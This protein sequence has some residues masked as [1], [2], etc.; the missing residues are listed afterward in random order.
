MQHGRLQENKALEY[1]QRVYDKDIMLQD[2]RA[3]FPNAE[4]HHVDDSIM[5]F[6]SPEE[7]KSNIDR[8]LR[9]VSVRKDGRGALKYSPFRAL[10]GI[11]L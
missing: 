8:I 1:L 4:W 11:A 7:L 9:R 10:K 5:L 6:Y 3:V 2:L